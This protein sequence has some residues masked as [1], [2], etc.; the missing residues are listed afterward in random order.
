MILGPRAVLE[1]EDSSQG[2]HPWKTYRRSTM[3][4]KR[5]THCALPHI[6]SDRV[7]S[8]QFGFFQ[9]MKNFVLK[10]E[11]RTKVFGNPNRLLSH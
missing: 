9:C 3:T 8:L 6:H 1:L 11:E 4:Q 7:N 5:L 10:N 2:P